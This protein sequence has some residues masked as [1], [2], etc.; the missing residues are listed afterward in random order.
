MAA[1]CPPTEELVVSVL[2][3]QVPVATDLRELVTALHLVEDL[4]RMGVLAHHIADLV[5]QR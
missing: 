2:A 4:S 1:S 3:R 5:Q